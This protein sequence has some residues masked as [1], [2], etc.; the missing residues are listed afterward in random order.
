MYNDFKPLKRSSNEHR[1]NKPKKILPYRKH[2]FLVAPRRYGKSS[3]CERA[4]EKLN[5]PSVIIDFHVATS[6]KTIERLILKGVVELIGHSIGSIEKSI[7]SIKHIFKN[8]KPKLSIEKSGFKFELETSQHASTP[9]VIREAILLLENLLKTKKQQAI[10]L[11]DE[12]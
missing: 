11:F 9:E 10:I 2:T 4:I 8:L 6:Q 7:Q 1:N 3:L 5:F 12:F